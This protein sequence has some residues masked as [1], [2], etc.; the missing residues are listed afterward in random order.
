MRVHVLI[1]SILV[2]ASL[3]AEAGEP[4]VVLNMASVVL[5][6]NTPMIP[7]IIRS[8]WIQIINSHTK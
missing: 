8:E 2:A 3:A 7:A 5:A 1:G 6:K 4:I